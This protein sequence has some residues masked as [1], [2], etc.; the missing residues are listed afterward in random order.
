MITR[1]RAGHY[2]RQIVRVIIRKC[3]GELPQDAAEWEHL[4]RRYGID[5]IPL[6]MS[7]PGF[8]A[9]LIAFPGEGFLLFYDRKGKP[10]LRARWF[11]HE[12]SE[13]LTLGDFPGQLDPPDHPRYQWNYDGG[14]DP[15]DARHQIARMVEELIFG[16]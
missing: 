6:A 11:C 10:E 1:Q 12:L 7:D 8:T 13:Y 9:R 3:G 4:I 15:A 2:A 14:D 16:R 5:V